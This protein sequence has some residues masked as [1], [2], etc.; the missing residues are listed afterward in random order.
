[1]K[2]LCEIPVAHLLREEIPGAR[3]MGS[4]RLELAELTVQHDTAA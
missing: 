4:L 1:M 3:V 2:V